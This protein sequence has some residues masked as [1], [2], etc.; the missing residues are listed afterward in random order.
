M[1][2]VIELSENERKL[3]LEKELQELHQEEEQPKGFSGRKLPKYANL[4]GFDQQEI[5]DRFG[6]C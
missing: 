2:K 5:Y 3:L 6:C 4:E 1:P